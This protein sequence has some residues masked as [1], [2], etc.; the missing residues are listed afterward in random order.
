MLNYKRTKLALNLFKLSNL[1]LLFLYLLLK[2][3]ILLN[4]LIDISTRPI[5]SCAD[6][7][8]GAYILKHQLH[9]LHRL[10]TC[11]VSAEGLHFR[12]C[13]LHLCRKR[14]R[15]GKRLPRIGCGRQIYRCL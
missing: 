14:T 13:F 9:V 11:L 12:P 15:G 1:I 4:N 8:F 3:L 10:L 2:L 7:I 5:I 6:Y